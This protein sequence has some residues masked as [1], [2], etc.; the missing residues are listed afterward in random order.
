MQTTTENVTTS[1]ESLTEPAQAAS[2]DVLHPPPTTKLPPLPVGF[3]P[4]SKRTFVGYRPSSREVTAA[5]T[6]LAD[7]AKFTTYREVLGGAAPDPDALASARKLALQWRATRNY[8]ATWQAYVQAQDAIAWKAV[9]QTLDRLKPLLVRA[10]ST[11]TLGLQY[12]GLMELVEAPKRS[13][14]QA[15]AT[16]KK[17]AAEKAPKEE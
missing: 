8:T 15:A 6:A 3:F 10:A 16:R 7:L 11:S 1:T 13:A 4:P 2:S 12:P 17:R 9:L 5:T 14:K